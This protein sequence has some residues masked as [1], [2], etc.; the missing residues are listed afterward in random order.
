MRLVF[1][2]SCLLYHAKPGFGNLVVVDTEHPA[3]MLGCQRSRLQKAG[4]IQSDTRLFA[5]QESY[6]IRKLA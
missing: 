5:I 6:E 2:K 4:V 3:K 1:W